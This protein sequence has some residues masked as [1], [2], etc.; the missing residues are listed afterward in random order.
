MTQ[1]TV[2]FA[3]AGRVAGALCRELYSAGHIIDQIVSES[4]RNGPVLAGECSAEWS[5][6][7]EF[8]A[9]TEII[10]VAVPDH[11]LVEILGQIECSNATLV[12]HTAGSFGIDLF[13]ERIEKRG[14]FYP[15][16]TFSSGR[17]VVF[18]EVPFFIESNDSHSL[19]IL[20]NLA[21]S[22]GARVYKANPDQ[23][24]Q[25]HLAAV[26]ANNF[27]NHMLASAKEVASKAGFSF[28]VL[29]P[30]IFETCSKAMSAGPENAQTGPAVRNDLNTIEKHLGM[31]SF[32]PRLSRLYGEVTQ[33]IIESAKGEINGQF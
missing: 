8:T 24:R 18:G 2:S 25:I 19:E 29:W 7:L 4:D 23:R 27:S 10:I 30:L 28:D 17:R 26:F 11:R 3:G 20:Q 15:L 9:K 21:G 22:L 1:Y 31:L 33:S 16:Q 12:V 14:V 5:D 6:T 32:S 13:P